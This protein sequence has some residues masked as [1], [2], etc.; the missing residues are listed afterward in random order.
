MLYS[1]WNLV[2]TLTDEN[3][4]HYAGFSKEVNS[5]APQESTK[6]EIEPTFNKM[7][8]KISTLH[9]CSSVSLNKVAVDT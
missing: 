8:E 5:L 9:D 6:I 7:F 3:Y 1:A 2:K 4:F